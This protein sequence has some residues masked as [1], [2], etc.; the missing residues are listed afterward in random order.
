MRVDILVPVYVDM[1]NEGI[2]NE[3]VNSKAPDV[4]LRITN[5][6]S[7]VP[8][9]E[10]AFDVAI[11]ARLVVEKAQQLQDEGSDG[12]I[13]YCFKDPSL[14]ACKEKLNIPVV[15]LREASIALAST[16]G[17]NISV[18]TSRKH[19]VSYYSRALKGKVKSVTCLGIPVLDF[20]DYSRVEKALEERVSEAVDLGCD[21]VVLGCGSILGVNFDRLEKEYGIS[22]IRPV[23][24]AVAVCD[25]LVRNG[26]RQSRIAYPL[27][28]IKII[29]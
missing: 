27:P 11:G 25:F 16:I 14:E 29:K 13:I 8:S 18:I 24:A 7:G 9:M 4:D 23:T 15:G 5:L 17:D 22:I 20:L 3:A 19:S 12:I 2:L 10:S 6:D 26:L 21:V 28:E 1:W